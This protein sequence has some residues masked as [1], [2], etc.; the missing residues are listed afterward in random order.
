MNTTERQIQDINEILSC[1]PESAIQEVKDFAFYLAEREKR[2][3]E[4]VERVLK[5]E[6]EPDTVICSSVEEFIQA[7]ENAE[8]DD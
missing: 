6:R 4:F 3:K 8:D 2:R 5:A 1:L 7:I